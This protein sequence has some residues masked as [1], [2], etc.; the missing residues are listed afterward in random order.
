[1]LEIFHYEFMQRSFIAG[2]LI[3]LTA[4]L[5]GIFLVVR[6]Y[7]LI[8]DTLAHVSLLGIAIGLILN[9]NPFI[10]AII[11]SVI[12]S[13]VIEKLGS[14]K[15]LFTE[16]ILSLF[17]SGALAMAVVLISIT[18]G[19]NANLYN[20]LFGSISI[21]SRNDI[22]IIATLASI[23]IFAVL[24]Y[25]KDL[26]LLSFDQE[27]AIVNKIPVK[28]LNLFLAI[29]A[30][31]QVSISIRAVGVL[32]IGALMVIPVIT[33]FQF[34]M[35]FKK[36]LILSIIFSEVSIFVGLYVSYYFD[37]ASGGTIVM[38][39]LVFFLASLLINKFKIRI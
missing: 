10:T 6:R 33:S 23:L 20:Y 21:V 38:L 28:F 3:G 26:F 5:I 13:V 2:A 29:L 32:L 7:S 25:F 19:F 34:G 30:A 18:K 17:L 35:G 36:T 14:E 37:L 4:P 24:Y 1:M 11:A 12:A 39:N 31:L 22:Y 9:V 8:A 27:L 15:K 16:S